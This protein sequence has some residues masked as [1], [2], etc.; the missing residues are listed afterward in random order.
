MKEEARESEAWR[1]PFI[2]VIRE[3][4]RKVFKEALAIACMPS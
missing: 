2:E 4:S 1:D 3:N